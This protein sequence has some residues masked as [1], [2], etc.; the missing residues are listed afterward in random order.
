L[1]FTY[2]LIPVSRGVKNQINLKTNG[3]LIQ[4]IW[5]WKI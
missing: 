4:N 2:I 3:K 1:L 5:I